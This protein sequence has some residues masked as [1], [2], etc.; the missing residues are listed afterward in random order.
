MHL[1]R[2]LHLIGHLLEVHLEVVEIEQ[3][4]D[5]EVINRLVQQAGL[6]VLVLPE[7]VLVSQQA[8]VAGFLGLKASSLERS[9]WGQKSC[10]QSKLGSYNSHDHIAYIGS[11]G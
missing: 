9:S 8:E 2:L 6:L 7:G 5:G 11:L 3:L 1:E 10:H 4:H